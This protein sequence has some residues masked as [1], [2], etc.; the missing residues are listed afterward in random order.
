MRRFLNT[1]EESV[2]ILDINKEIVYLNKSALEGLGYAEQQIEM[3]LLE[4]KVEVYGE[5]VYL[6]IRNNEGNWRQGTLHTYEVMINEELCLLG[7][8][9][10]ANMLDS[11]RRAHLLEAFLENVNRD[12]YIKDKEGKYIYANK[13]YRSRIN[14]LGKDITGTTD[15][16]YWGEQYGALFKDSDDYTLET[17]MECVI[18]DEMLEEEKYFETTKFPIVNEETYI[19]VITKD[20]TLQKILYNQLVEAES[21]GNSLLNLNEKI[22]RAHV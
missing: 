10:W 2:C 7:K 5:Q 4:Q 16:D 20:I 13:H 1:L 18:E 15:V 9:Q 12:I 11:R 8:I 19:G 17:N 22:G 14:A 6:H 3:E 21:E